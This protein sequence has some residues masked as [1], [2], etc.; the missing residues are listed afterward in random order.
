MLK[1][2]S[3]KSLLLFGVVLALAAFVLPSV[4][5]AAGFEPVGTGTI[6]SGNLGFSVPAINSG[7]FCTSSQ[8]HMQVHSTTV[9]TITAS[10]IANCHGSVGAS[11][12]CT[13]T[14]TGTGF[15]WVATAE[16]THN[17]IIHNVN[18]H[19]VFE[20]TPGTLNECANTGLTLRLTGSLALQYTA[21]AHT[22]DFTSGSTFVGHFPG[23]A[24]FP[25]V[26]FGSLT[27]TGALRVI[28]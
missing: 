14:W 3:K 9:A 7:L 12:G 20:T 18:I 23:P 5:S 6:D 1:M 13:T 21:A 16:S 19:V 10:R 28:D 25:L 27:P 26:L 11:V 4:A 15:P 22:F 17:I 8:F 2:V 24:T